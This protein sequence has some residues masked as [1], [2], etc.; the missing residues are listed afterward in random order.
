MPAGTPLGMMC[1]MKKLFLRLLLAGWLVLNIPV[2]HQAIDGA[3]GMCHSDG[4]LLWQG[5]V[6]S[7]HAV[8]SHGH[9]AIALEPI[10]D[11]TTDAT[12]LDDGECERTHHQHAAFDVPCGM[13]M[14]LPAMRQ[15]T[16]ARMMTAAVMFHTAEPPAR[17]PRREL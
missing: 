10:T 5:N 14:Y 6:S 9:A 13:Q 15:Q 7:S 4:Q 1:I 16:D 2:L 17:P 3:S 11:A 8:E 12:A